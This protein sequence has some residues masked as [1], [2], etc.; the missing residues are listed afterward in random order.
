MTLIVKNNQVYSGSISKCTKNDPSSE[1]ILDSTT[2]KLRGNC[3]FVQVK[4]NNLNEIK[5]GNVYSW[6]SVP[7]AEPPVDML[8]FKRTVAKK[9]WPETLSATEWPNACIQQA[10]AEFLDKNDSNGSFSGFE[11][12][13]P[14]SKHIKFSEDCLYLNIIIG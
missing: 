2:G 5:S 6:L 8:R 9:P 10:Q 1:I 7:Y 14:S 4:D 12:W 11:M 3:Q 13:E